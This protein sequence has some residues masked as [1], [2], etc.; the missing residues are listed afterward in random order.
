MAKQDKR[1]YKD[2]RQYLIVAVIALALPFRGLLIL[3]PSLI[4]P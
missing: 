4:L 3:Q 1:L 2:H